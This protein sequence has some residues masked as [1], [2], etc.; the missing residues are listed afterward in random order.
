MSVEGA[1]SLLRRH[2]HQSPVLRPLLKEN[3]TRE[4]DKMEAIEIVNTLAQL[5][6]GLGTLGILLYVWIVDRRRADNCQDEIVE[7]WK[8]TRD[9]S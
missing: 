8:R 9:R 5:A 4:G 1:Y 6:E 3:A 7:D 2:W